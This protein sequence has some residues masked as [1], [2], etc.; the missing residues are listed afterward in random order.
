MVA[1]QEA[2]AVSAEMSAT[3]ERTMSAF[4]SEAEEDRQK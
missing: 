1:L 3:L 2:M 4:L